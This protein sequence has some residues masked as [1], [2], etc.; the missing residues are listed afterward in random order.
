MTDLPFASFLFRIERG[1]YPAG[2]RG[3]TLVLHAVT[4]FPVV[5]AGRFCL[6]RANLPLLG[7]SRA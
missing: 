4:F 1:G 5:L 3:I 2:R 7:P 6:W